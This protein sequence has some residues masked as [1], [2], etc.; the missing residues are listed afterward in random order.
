MRG[1]KKKKEMGFSCGEMSGHKSAEFGPSGTGSND[2][3][4][5][6]TED[7][8]HKIMKSG[9]HSSLSTHPFQRAAKNS[10]QEHKKKKERS[11]PFWKI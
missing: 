8:N 7:Q 4:Q 3:V 6:R 1:R 9:L 11:L 5:Q 2:L 10:H